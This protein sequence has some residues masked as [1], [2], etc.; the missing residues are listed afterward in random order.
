[1]IKYL[2]IPLCAFFWAW[3]GAEH[4]SRAWRWVLIPMLIALV[5]WNPWCL[6]IMAPI[7]MG[8]GES[9]WLRKLVKSNHLT[10][11]ILGASYGALLFPFVWYK[12]VVTGL[13]TMVF[14]AIIQTEP[15][16]KIFGKHLNTE[17]MI[18]GGTVG[19]MACL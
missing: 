5:L 2:L 15:S 12:P 14:G 16:I 11:L 18:I 6:F 13:V 19:L 8:Y 17:E 10:R 3:G 1:M 7:S 9:S 4:T